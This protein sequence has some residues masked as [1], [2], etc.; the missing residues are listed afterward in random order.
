MKHIADFF[1][2][3]KRQ[4]LNN[5]WAIL[6]ASALGLIMVGIIGFFANDMTGFPV[7]TLMIMFASFFMIILYG[8]MLLQTKFDL[9]LSMGATRKKIVVEYAAYMLISVIMFFFAGII[10]VHVEDFVYTTLLHLPEDELNIYESIGKIAWGMGPVY[11][12]ESGIAVLVA[13]ASL[14]WG[15]KVWW[16]FYALALLLCQVPNFINMKVEK[17]S[18]GVVYETLYRMITSNSAGEWLICAGVAVVLSVLAWL[19]LRKQRVTL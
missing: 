14:R 13:G 11:L 18:R 15:R 1:A 7:G 9:L 17:S 8:S 10:N 4:L 16:V 5:L 6:G 2:L 12:V 19:T 3:Y